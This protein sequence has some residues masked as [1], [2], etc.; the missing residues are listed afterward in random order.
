M[1]MFNDI[2]CEGKGNKQQCLRDADYVKTFAKR[3][4]IGQ[5]SFIGPGS[6]KK[7]YPSE[8]NPQGEWDRIAEEM[9]LEFAKSG[10][11]IFRAT[12]PLSR[13]KLKS[14]GK[15]KVSIHFCAEPETIDT[16]YRIIL[17]VNQLSVYG[18]V[19]AICEEF[20]GQPDNTGQPV[21]L[22]GQSIVLG[23]V[24]A[25]A[26]AQEESR[27]SNVTLQKYFQQVRQLSPEDKLGKFCKEAGFMSV[28]EVGQYFVTR[29]ASEFLL[30]T[31]ACREYTLPRD[32][33]ASE[34]K[35]WIQGNTRI[36]PILEVT[37]TFQHFK[38]GVE[39]LIP[40]VKGDNSQS[41]VRISFGTIRYVNHYVKHNTHNFA[42]F[43]EEKAEP[44][45]SEVI[46]ARS[47]AKAKPQ[48]R[49]SSATT[50][51]SISERVWIDI[52]PSRQDNESHKVSKRVINILRHNQSVYREPDG[53]VQ[54][55]KIKI[56]MKEHSL[57]TQ[58][59]S[60]S[61][62]LICLAAGGGIKR[63]F[64]YC[65]DYLGTIL[66]LRALQGHSGDSI[67]DLETQ[68][69]VL[70]K[71]GIFTYI[72]HVG[73]RFNLKSIVS[74]GLVPGGQELNGRQS[75]YFLPVDP[76]DEDHRD[77]E[78]IDY[79]VPRRARYLHKSW[80]RHQDTVF[81][82]N[83]DRGIIREGL[84]FYQTKSNAIILQGVL[85][86]SCIVKAERLKGGEKL[87]ERQYLSPRSPPKIVLRD[88]LDWA[89]GNNKLGST[90]EH[91]PVGKLV[92]QSLGETA[93]HDSPKPTQS[94]KTNR[95]STGQPV[96]QDVVVVGALQE[97][98]SS[99][100]STGQPVAKE[101]QHVQTHDSSGQPES[102]GTQHIVQR[103]ENRKHREIVDQFNLATNNANIDFSVSGIPE[104][105]VKRSETMSILN[106]IRTIARHPQQEAVQN[107]LDKKQSFNAFSAESKKAIK[108]SGNI[109][110]SEIVNT[111][112]K[113][114]CK[115]CLNH[116][117]PGIIYCVCGHLMVEDSGEHRKYMLSALNSFT[118]GNFYV[119][120]GRP[121]GYRY[122]KA[123]EC[124]EYH[125]AH[126][127]AKKCRKKGFDSIYDRYMRDK[128]FRSNMID[129]GR[130]EKVIIDMDNLANE[131]HSFK[132]TQNERNYYSQ[133]WWVHSNVIH[134]DARDTPPIRYESGFKEALSTMQRLK[135]AEDKKKQDTTSQPSSSSSSWQWQSS[136]WESDYEHSPQKWDYH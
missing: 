114:Q 43:Y 56:L 66:Y 8:N 20:V 71:P 53:A 128:L 89:E 73:S 36:G 92:Q 70:I 42:S 91:R 46:A 64:Q 23:E 9:L 131:D 34:A 101:G 135:R 113:L 95:D 50:T 62:W 45:S 72:Y 90:V 31:V 104:E 15:G 22:E 26:P 39:V 35:G 28:V 65:P 108:E 83:I 77:P 126:Q 116:C 21:V 96:A 33:P 132:V 93:H 14:K 94:P 133:N 32:D 48:P 40:S 58:Y 17:S 6:E 109:E 122:G 4:G 119:C 75:V 12:T 125:T 111:E 61:Q 106:L 60:D 19:A 86:P 127:L 29:N 11:P 80:K 121:R 68:D 18:A 103:Q 124:K 49:E 97:E 38:F 69:H 136:W 134:E 123:P 120:K 24:E 129:H 13:G 118:I 3:F 85:P 25:E 81:W 130:T 7:W 82:V 105:T 78:V 47:K 44:A 100:D 98:P 51:M 16:I 52:V 110:I 37:T 63:R 76:R 67:I 1:S 5:W 117:N 27:N 57:S 59:W 87:Y 102:E 84:R 79:S 30:E 55:Y 115:F 10:H 2:S 112:P 74:N 88:D 107:D 54:F 41:W 99:S